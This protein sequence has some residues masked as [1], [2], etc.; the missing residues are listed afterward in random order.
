MKT[1]PAT[2]STS[3]SV[4]IAFRNTEKKLAIQRP[5]PRPHFKF[6][7]VG[8]AVNTILAFGYSA[9]ATTHGSSVIHF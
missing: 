9:L 5:Q 1:S 6:G 3:G 2:R 7:M 4:R 8:L